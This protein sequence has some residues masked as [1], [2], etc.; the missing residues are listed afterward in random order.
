MFHNLVSPVWAA[1]GSTPREGAA[2]QTSTARAAGERKLELLRAVAGSLRDEA[3]TA[4]RQGRLQDAVL[5]YRESLVYFPDAGLNDYILELE[6]RAGRPSPALAP[7]NAPARP[8]GSASVRNRSRQSIHMLTEGAPADAST[9]LAPDE[10]RSLNVTWDTQ[11]RVSFRAVRDGKVIASSVW[12]RDPGDA[13]K[14]PV[15]LFDDKDGPPKLT[16]MTGIK[17][18]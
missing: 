10:I 4:Q 2:G 11:G 7:G 1:E 15:V 17:L 12:Q 9:L 5:L 8:S 14:V 3:Y 18:R 13:R 6:K 16:V